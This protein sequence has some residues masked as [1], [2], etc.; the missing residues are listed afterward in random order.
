MKPSTFD[1]FT[2]WKSNPLHF[3]PH[4]YVVAVPL[5]L[6]LVA[7]LVDQTWMSLHPFYRR[8]LATA[9]AVRRKRRA[10]GVEYAAP[11]DFDREATPLSTY[12]GR[13]EGHPQVIFAA[14]ANLSGFDR[15]PPGRRATSYTFSHDWVGGPLVGYVRTAAL[16]EETL[17]KSLVRDLTVQSAMAVSGA[18]FASAMG[19]EARAF[20]TLLALSNARLGTWLPNPAWLS[21]RSGAGEWLQPR[22]PRIRRLT[23]LLREI[24]GSFDPADRFLLVTDGGHYENLGL[25]ELLRHRCRTAYCIDAAGDA[26]PLATTLGEAMALAREE[27]G[28]TITLD[29]PLD[30]VPGSA[31]ALT[32][33]DPLAE[34]SARLSKAVVV[35]GTIRYPEAFRLDGEDRASDR[36]R[37]IVAKTRLHREMSADL[38][39]YAQRNPTFPYDSTSDQWFDHGQFNAF[40]EL[41]AFLG[42]KA[43]EAEA[44]LRR[45]EQGRLRRD[46][47]DL[48]RE[49]ER[50]GRD[51]QRRTA[52]S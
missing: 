48:A 42:E 20:Q 11:Y 7:A 22:I 17:K 49:Q 36:G 10:D 31:D 18:A 43:V 37:L 32:P 47:A 52:E 39:S 30:L 41:G 1:A 23:Y 12:A 15:T 33:E 45:R 51:E 28:V 44:V 24:A 16:T 50:Q 3:W 9:F 46:Q 35:T 26:P 40:Y 2:F 34:L 5:V 13:V 27:L 21:E 4:W 8:R 38:L 25:V 14:S 29:N 19:R 6:A